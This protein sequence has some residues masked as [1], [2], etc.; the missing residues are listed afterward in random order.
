MI[1]SGSSDCS[2]IYIIIYFIVVVWDVSL[3]NMLIKL[4]DH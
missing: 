4:G 2:G 1:V 3:Q